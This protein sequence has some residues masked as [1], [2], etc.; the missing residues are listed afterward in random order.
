MMTMPHLDESAA[1]KLRGVARDH[2][3]AE[4]ASR[5]L[6]ELA[7]A[8]DGDDDLEPWAA[9]DLR[10]AFDPETALKLPASSLWLGRCLDVLVFTPVASTW[11]GLMVATAA[12]KSTL[13]DPKLAGE[14]F[15]QRWQAGFDGHVWAGLSFDRVA[16]I[17][18]ALVSLILALALTHF[19]FRARAEQGPRARA[20]R[21]LSEAI[22]AA[23]KELAPVRLGAVGR[24]A[25]EVGK[26]SAEV[27]VTAGEV[28]KVGEA[29]GRA[30]QAAGETIDRVTAAMTAVQA[31]AADVAQAVMD[32]GEKLA[33]ATAATSSVAATEA[34]FG[35]KLLDATEKLDTTVAGL[36][37]RLTTAVASG[38]T[39]L[40]RSV[41]E[42]SERV[43]ES[44]S[45]GAG[46]V[47]DA[48]GE[49]KHTAAANAGQVGAAVA[50]LADV[51]DA[52]LQLPTALGRLDAEVARL[53]DG[54]GRLTGAIDAMR[55]PVR[56]P[57]PR[58]AM[59]GRTDRYAGHDGELRGPGGRRPGPTDL[60]EPDTPGGSLLD[61]VLRR[62]R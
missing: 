32:M 62:R 46:Q 16:V 11:L 22:T 54:I 8:L 10:A 24:V 26:V 43:A 4:E 58:P 40:T 15:L 12:Y 6:G 47:R 13:N 56:A 30:Q 2:A 50:S 3:I 5:T 17:T 28:R 55:V 31:A 29:A 36:A 9:V 59:S 38:Q 60:V 48:I 14:N 52:A 7:S 41:A 21:L 34:E 19:G 44:L 20:Y 25:A 37:D 27:A 61:R 57:L 35:E 45:E 51:K 49:L 39:Q 18:F 53:N 23:E 33:E 42:S 1:V